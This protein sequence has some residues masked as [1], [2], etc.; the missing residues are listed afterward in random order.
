MPPARPAPSRPRLRAGPPARRTHPARRTRAARQERDTYGSSSKARILERSVFS[1]RM[2]FVRAVKASGDLQDHEL[3]IYDAW[4]G[5][6]SVV[7]V[8][9]VGAGAGGRCV[10]LLLRLAPGLGTHVRSSPAMP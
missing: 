6:V 10:D 7:W 5:W 9:C 3:A 1:D 2:V 4:F 8:K